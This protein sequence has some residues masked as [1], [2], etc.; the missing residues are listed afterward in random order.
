MKP[1]PVVHVSTRGGPFVG[2][3]ASV[4]RRRATKMLRHL[5]LGA[6]ELSVALVDDPTIQALSVFVFTLG[7]GAS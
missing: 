2:V 4:V 5:E 6:V 1:L 7:G 3:S